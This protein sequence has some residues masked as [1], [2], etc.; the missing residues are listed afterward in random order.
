[1]SNSSKVTHIKSNRSWCDLE[2]TDFFRYKDL[3]YL[4]IRRDLVTSY[5]QTILGPLWVVIQALMG[6]AVFTVVFGNIAALIGI[7]TIFTWL[8]IN[9]I[10]RRLLA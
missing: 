7:V 6:S 5:K 10:L 3:I 8:L 9:F 1:M 2:V 4:L